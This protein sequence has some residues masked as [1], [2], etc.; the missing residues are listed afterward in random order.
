MKL[1]LLQQYSS[2]L[3]VYGKPENLFVSDFV[4]NPSI[5]LVNMDAEMIPGGIGLSTADMKLKFIPNEHLELP[6]HKKVVL[7]IRPEF[8]K[9]KEDSRLE[10]FVESSLPSG[11]ETILVTRIGHQR[12]TSVIFGS[13]DFKVNTKIHMGFEGN[14]YLLFDA[15]TGTRLG[16]GALEV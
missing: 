10:T 16:L 8:L 6:G 5:N 15:E 2:P 3:E 7:G 4:G 11:M 14:K 12:L 9:Q 13:V 1:G